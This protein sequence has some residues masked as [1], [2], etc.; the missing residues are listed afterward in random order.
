MRTLAAAA[1]LIALLRPVDIGAEPPGSRAWVEISVFCQCCEPPWGKNSAGI[2]PFFER[3][4][5][6]VLGYR[7]EGRMVCAACSCPPLVRQMIRVR[8]EDVPR[9]R[10]LLAEASTSPREGPRLSP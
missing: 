1:V 7:K 6:R 10:A 8:A 2:R 4:G 5:I 9:V 3:H